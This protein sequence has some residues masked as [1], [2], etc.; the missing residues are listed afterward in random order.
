MLVRLQEMAYDIL[1]EVIKLL[2]CGAGIR[3]TQF[4]VILEF[5]LSST[6]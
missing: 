5:G 3:A 6:S 2:A 4:H 1:Y